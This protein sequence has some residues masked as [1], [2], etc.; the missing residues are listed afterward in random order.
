MQV[1]VAVAYFNNKKVIKIITPSWNIYFPTIDIKMVLS[2][3]M[4]PY[5]DFK[6]HYG[7]LLKED[8]T[9]EDR[10]LHSKLLEAFK[11]M[12]SKNIDLLNAMNRNK[13][14]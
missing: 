6:K 7:D 2:S 3:G 13:K 8:P 5:I 1:V 4:T 10:R 14:K 11:M 12:E 9:V